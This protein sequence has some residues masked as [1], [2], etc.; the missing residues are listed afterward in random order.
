MNLH[1]EKPSEKQYIDILKIYALYY[2]NPKKI[3]DK[4]YVRKMEDTGFVVGKPLLYKELANSPF[5]EVACV[6]SKVVGFIR[7]DKATN[8]V[9]SEKFK[10]DWLGNG[11]EWKNFISDAELQTDLDQWVWQYNHERT[12]TGKY[13]F[14]RTPYQTF[15]ETKHLAKEKMLDTLFSPSE[16]PKSAMNPDRFGSYSTVKIFAGTPTLL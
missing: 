2:L 4:N 5:F 1:F 15:Q 10:L 12:H 3:S 9:C 7:A 14:G 13:C 8:E 16:K 11:D 6:D